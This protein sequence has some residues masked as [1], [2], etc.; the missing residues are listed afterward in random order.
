MLVGQNDT[1]LPLKSS[2]FPMRDLL[3]TPKEDKKL[4]AY[5]VPGHN[6]R[7]DDAVKETHSWLDKYFG[8]VR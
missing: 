6:V 5:D 1:M 2:Q 7:W 4:V 8:K 3:G